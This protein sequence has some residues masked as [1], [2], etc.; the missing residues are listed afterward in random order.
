MAR[1]SGRSTVLGNRSAADR[2]KA[3]GVHYTPPD[4]A[5]FLAGALCRHATPRENGPIRVL[6]PACGDGSLLL[7]LAEA[8]PP[9]IQARLELVGYDTDASALAKASATLGE[10]RDV[11][12]DLR[13]A[14]FLSLP[15]SGARREASLFDGAGAQAAAPPHFDFVIAN[16]PYVRTQVLGA[17]RA[18]QLA[19]AYDL[20]G[21]VDLYHAFVK[22]IAASLR[23]GGTLG[24]LT[25][26]RFLYTQAGA[27]TR[28]ALLRDFELCHLF[29]LGDTKLFAAA[30]LPAILIARRSLEG[31]A[32]DCSFT[33]IYEVR[34]GDADH[35]SAVAYQSI[36]EATESETRGMV[37]IGSSHFNI[38]RGKIALPKSHRYPWTLSSAHIDEWLAT[39]AK[40]SAY[41]FADVA[42]VRVGIKTTA[43]DVFIRD[44]W[45]CL[46]DDQSPE[47][48]L[49]RPLLRSYMADCWLPIPDCTKRPQVLYPHMVK[50]GRR[51][52]ISL[53]A[54]P[55]ARAYLERYRERL[56][57]RRYVIEAGRQWYEIWVPQNPDDW[58]RAKIVFP[59]ISENPRF[60]LDENGSIVNGDCYWIMLNGQQDS[61]WLPLML[62]VANSTFILKY[63]DAVFGNKLYAGRRRFITQYVQRFPLPHLDHPAAGQIIRLVPELVRRSAASFDRSAVA[64]RIDALVW[65]AFGLA[66]EVAGQGNLQLG[67]P[68]QPAEALER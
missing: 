7:A 8:T 61:R 37:A 5:A 11:F 4:L 53:D 49:L 26:N 50:D 66:K 30:V 34:D 25:S 64:E 2:V 15:T 51:K 38:E 29:D 23:A 18:Q 3:N 56:T 40:H 55:K 63:Y 10:L 27:A 67:I 1:R 45:H 12:T 60:F 31:H 59:D 6:D 39:V 52:A 24:L 46:P 19:A 13:N 42:K 62:A 32:G 44:N 54:Y 36:L 43:D 48:E 47:P 22:A 65:A 17:E 9:T 35:S 33:R 58:S 14:D 28:E 21:R 41:T 16:P 68:H 57:S 20:S